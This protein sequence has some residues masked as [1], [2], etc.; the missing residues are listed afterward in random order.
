MS[1]ETVE[2]SDDTSYLEEDASGPIEIIVE[3]EKFT[4]SSDLFEIIKPDTT[5]SYVRTKAAG[6]ITLDVN[7]S[8][9][10]RYRS[11]IKIAS[12]SGNEVNCW[13]EDSYDNKDG[14]IYNITGYLTTINTGP[15]FFIIAK[16][17]T[18]LRT[19]LHKLK[20]HFDD[21]VNIDWIKFTLIKKYVTTPKTLKQ[22]TEGS[23]W[24]LVWSDE[25][26]KQEIDTTKWS[27]DIGDWGWGNNEIQYYTEGR[28]ENARIENGNLIIEAR[29][30]DM[31]QKWTSARLTT[32]GK[33][34]FVYGKIELRAKVPS[35][36]GNWAAGWTQGDDYIDE[37]SWPHCGKIDI[38]ESVGYNMN[39]ATGH[40]KAH[41]STHSGAAYFNPVNQPTGIAAVDNMNNEF[42]TYSVEWKP[43]LIT[44]FVDGLPYLSYDDS[45]TDLSW[46]FSKPQ[47]IILNLAMG[48]G[49]AGSQGIDGRIISQ[50]MIIDYVRVYELQ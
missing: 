39:D 2:S 38:L 32:H 14:R 6:W 42:H 22:N 11:Q 31:G 24:K 41:A 28:K 29:K 33:V 47:N 21:D 48:G 49:W 9:A 10:G 40:G 5:T 19:G 15:Q 50:K 43:D 44:T 46:P 45:S 1:C 30:N 7:I 4:G 20:I 13:I 18:P 16:D 35:N 27:F 17:G 8:V 26:D 3:A 34:S 25:F 36:K 23:E 12:E 37:L